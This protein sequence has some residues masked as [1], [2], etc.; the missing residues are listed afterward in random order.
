MGRGTKQTFVQRHTNDRR[1]HEKVVNTTKH[2]D[3]AMKS[4]RGIYD[5]TPVGM[6][7][8]KKRSVAE[9]VEKREPYCTVRGDVNDTAAMENSMEIPQK[10][11][12]RVIEQFRFWLFT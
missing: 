1:V 4:T 5:L 6:N 10:S 3:K 7:V 12:S 8:A 2:Q 11:N 9:D